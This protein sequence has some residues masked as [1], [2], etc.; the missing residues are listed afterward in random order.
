M[1][2]SALSK[3]ANQVLQAI[4]EKAVA[5]RSQE[6]KGA[7]SDPLRSEVEAKIGRT[8][9]I[10]FHEDYPETGGL[11]D[12]SF[13][14]KDLIISIQTKILRTSQYLESLHNADP[15]KDPEMKAILDKAEIAQVNAESSQ[16]SVRDV[17]SAFQLV[18]ET[19]LLI[20]E[21][22]KTALFAVGA[23]REHIDVSG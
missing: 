5:I 10:L 9:D 6:N 1:R 23:V 15:K 22:S 14:N 17:N 7:T 21:D 2:R 18:Q 4:R 11:P 8:L 3:E 13:S 19:S 20:G 12:I 16:T